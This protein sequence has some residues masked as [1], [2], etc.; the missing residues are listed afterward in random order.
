[1]AFRFLRGFRT[2][3]G[4][5]SRL[6]N[7]TGTINADCRGLALIVARIAGHQRISIAARCSSVT[8]PS[9]PS[10]IT[11][12]KPPLSQARVC[13]CGRKTLS[14]AMTTCGG[15]EGNS[16]SSQSL[17]LVPLVITWNDIDRSSRQN[18]SSARQMRGDML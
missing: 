14:F 16:P 12:V 17:S 13:P 8:F 4:S 1:V 11:T 10:T 2:H 6:A 18:P 9:R 15:S 3:F 7:L 5:R